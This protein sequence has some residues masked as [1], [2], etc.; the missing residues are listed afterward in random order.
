MTWNA[1]TYR[2]RA[3]KWREEAETLPPGKDRDSCLE[4]AQGYDHLADLI[5]RENEGRIG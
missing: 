3:R 5:D 4:L 1:Q 2:D